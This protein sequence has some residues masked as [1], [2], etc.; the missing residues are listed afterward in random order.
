MTRIFLTTIAFTLLL[1]IACSGDKKSPTSPDDESA[2]A[3]T[4]GLL[5]FATYHYRDNTDAVNHPD[6]AGAL[7]TFNWRDIEAAQGVYDWSSVEADIAP[8]IAAGKKVALRLQW[9]ANGAWADPR[10]DTP[11]PQWVWDV[12]AKFAWSVG[13]GTEVPLQWDPVYQEHAEKFL[14]T[15]ADKWD[16]DPRLLFLDVTP[17]GETN[18]YRGSIDGSDAAFASVFAAT[19][20]SDGRTY[21]DTLWVQT[22]KQMINLANAAFTQTPLL[23]TLNRGSIADGPWH[24][25]EFGD[26]AISRGCMVG[27]NGLGAGSFPPEGNRAGYF[28]NWKPLT[29]FYFEMVGSSTGTRPGPIMGVMQAAEAI[30]ADYLGVYPQDV[31]LSLPGNPDYDAAYDEALHYGASVIGTTP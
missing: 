18:P 14:Q 31:L 24:F 19:P 15:V 23:V 5:Y 7:F 30:Q 1:A 11:T 12:G 28:R 27:Q 13:T 29:R 17:G 16:G 2:P 3:T 20:A 22:V 26:Y 10:H 8:W 21:D 9:S 25:E 6:L 4:G